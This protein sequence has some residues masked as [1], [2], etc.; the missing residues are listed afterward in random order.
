MQYLACCREGTCDA[1]VVHLSPPCADGNPLI[2]LFKISQC[3]THS[4]SLEWHGSILQDMQAAKHTSIRQY[5]KHQVARNESGGH[6]FCE[7][8]EHQIL[9]VSRNKVFW[10]YGGTAP[11]SNT[12]TPFYPIPLSTDNPSF[13]IVNFFYQAVEVQVARQG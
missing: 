12:A 3:H 9:Q 13:P 4:P 8:S 10:Y 6:V 7:S 5:C 11:C 2:T 1:G